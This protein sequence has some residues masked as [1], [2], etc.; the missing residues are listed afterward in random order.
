MTKFTKFLAVVAA[1]VIVAGAGYGI[2]K[3]RADNDFKKIIDE[4]VEAEHVEDIVNYAVTDQQAALARVSKPNLFLK[5]GQGDLD[6]IEPSLLKLLK[7]N[8]GIKKSGFTIS[9]VHL[10]LAHQALSVDVSGDYDRDNV[11]GGLSLAVAVA[12]RSIGNQSAFDP[13]LTGVKVDGLS[14]FG[15]NLDLVKNALNFVLPPLKDV[16]SDGLR[17][18]LEPLTASLKIQPPQISNFKE[19]SSKSTTSEG[20][21][22]TTT[23]VEFAPRPFVY[24]PTIQVSP[25]MSARTAYSPLPTR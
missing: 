16:I 9:R 13:Y 3:Y 1:F 20:G 4:I 24:N 5:L 18:T 7:D 8:E 15:V 25:C 17:A 6:K 14:V 22:T 11:K 10:G 19:L 21:S 23:D 2:Y 12:I